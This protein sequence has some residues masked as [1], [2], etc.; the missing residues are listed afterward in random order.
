MSEIDILRSKINDYRRKVHFNSLIKG[1]LQFAISSAIIITFI[2]V[3]EHYFWFN[4]FTRAIIFYVV[5]FGLTLLFWFWLLSPLGKMLQLIPSELSDKILAE[6][7]G[8]FFPE[9]KD[10]LLNALQLEQLSSS[11]NSLINAGISSHLEKLRPIPFSNGINYRVNLK[12]VRY[13]LL[14]MLSMVLFSLF[15][16]GIYSNST[17]RVIDYDK[18]YVKPMPFAIH[19]SHES[20]YAFRGEPY[21]ITVDITGESLPTE[22]YFDDGNRLQYLRKI[23]DNTFTHTIDNVQDNITYSIQAAGFSSKLYSIEVFDRASLTGMELILQYPLHTGKQKEVTNQGKL[24]IPEGTYVTWNLRTSGTDISTLTVNDSINQSFQRSDNQIYTTDYQFLENAKYSIK[25]ENNFGQNL[26]KIQY[27][28]DVIADQYPQ[29]EANFYMDTVLYEFIIVSGEAF[30]DYGIKSV[31]ISGLENNQIIYNELLKSDL[32]QSSTSF[33]HRISIDSLFDLSTNNKSRSIYVS[34]DDNDVINNFK[35]VRSESFMIR[36]PQREELDAQLASKS[37]ETTDGLQKSIDKANAIND[38]IEEL[39]ERLLNKKSLEWQEEKLLEEL[40][41]Q[42]KQIEEEVQ[43]LQNKFDE[44]NKAENKF[45]DRSKEIQE[46][47]EQL[48]KLM[49]EVLDEETKKMYEELQKLMEENAD[50]EDLKNQLDQLSGNEDNLE[51]EL[52]RALELFKRLKVETELEKTSQKIEELSA[53]QEELAE[54]T[55]NREEE[56]TKDPSS[57]ENEND[58]EKHISEQE[59]L[60]EE[61]EEVQEQIENIQQLNQE[62]KNPEPI[63]DLSQDLEQIEKGMD[64]AKDLLEQQDFQNGSQQ[65]K[66]NSQKLKQLGQKMS[67]MMQSMQMEMISEDIDNLRNILDNLVKLSFRQ[68]DLINGFYEVKQIDPKFVELSQDQLK[69][70]EDAAIIEDSLL[71]LSQRVVQ[72]SSFITREVGLVNDNVDAALTNLRNRDRNKALSN[73]QFAM[74]SIN[75]LAL[76]LDDLLKQM[77][78]AMSSGM[79]KGKPQNSKGEGLPNLK[80][81]QKNL[82][83]QIQQLKQGQKKGRQ[84]SESLA[85]MAAQQEM[86]REKLQ[87]LQ[88]SMKGQPNGEEAGEAMEKAM[89]LMEQNEIDLVNRRLTQELI[90]RQEEIITRMLDAENAMKEQEYD[91]ERK[92]ETAEEVDRNIPKAFQEY[93][94]ERKKQIE[95]QKTIPIGLNPFYKKEVNDYFR[96]LSTEN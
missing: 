72:M 25:L 45:S 49:N 86:L 9:V 21:T 61:F 23:D 83:Q 42:R 31:S 65:Q 32:N 10:K 59:K 56:N 67:Q 51:K 78:N 3:L 37:Q 39:R 18:N 5:T 81:L 28:V 11:D 94:L 89:K 41:D 90:N 47:S 85:K 43:K 15:I 50:V 74:A 70:K 2:S 30:D 14:I 20:P 66:D 58:G 68:E 82:S 80:E 29:L 95:L 46:K 62:L 71:S 52:E 38:K 16:P 53:K 64:K 73:Q 84:L 88:N 63:Q 40:L 91:N 79:S 24:N 12:Y 22:T 19:V 93:L 69:L 33:Y 55:Q 26:E 35:S 57:S 1:S 87:E 60:N 6:Q 96:R 48:Q 36:I 92:G 75:N 54:D 7:I 77:Q 13:A 34:V 17:K 4:S 8:Q 27:Q 76:L 44:L